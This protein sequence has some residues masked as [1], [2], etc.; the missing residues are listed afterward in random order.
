MRESGKERRGGSEGGSKGVG[1]G[2][3][4]GGGER[5]SVPPSLH[6]YDPEAVPSVLGVL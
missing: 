1:G 2:G 6:T 3:G 5:G 4:G